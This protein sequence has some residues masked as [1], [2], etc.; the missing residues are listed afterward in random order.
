M[1]VAIVAAVLAVQVKCLLVVCGL[2]VGA[3]VTVSPGAATGS[4]SRA[5]VTNPSLKPITGAP[6]MPDSGLKLLT[7]AVPP[8]VV[9]VDSS[10]AT[11]VSGVTFD[12]GTLWTVSIAGTA[13]AIVSAPPGRPSVIY[14]IRGSSPYEVISLGEGVNAWSAGDR[15]TVWISERAGGRCTI[16]R[17]NLGG[18]LVRAATQF[19]C[20]RLRDPTAG[21]LGVVVNSRRIINPSTRRLVFSSDS[22]IM[23]VAG[24]QVLL[25][26]NSNELAIADTTSQR[27]WRL[28]WPSILRGTDQAITGPN[29]RWIAVSFGD[30]AWNGGPQQ[31]IDLWMLDVKT[32]KFTHVPGM[33]ALVALKGTSI[34]WSK[35]N[36][37]VLLS[38]YTGKDTVGVWRVGEAQLAIKPIEIPGRQTS[39]SDTFAPLG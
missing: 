1:A 13:G 2:S 38:Q 17:V 36:R 22:T 15:R 3:A 21:Q 4:A 23:A 28:R 25:D 31:A 24:K 27:M 11:P 32:R 10:V 16:R 37:L 12:S 33:P 29:A 34:A 8:V 35:D 14:A 30:P 26:R 18:Q 5:M 19:P 39:G 6:L 20:L 9:D 7:S